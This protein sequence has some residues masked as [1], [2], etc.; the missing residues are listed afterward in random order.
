[1]HWLRILHRG[2]PQRCHLDGGRKSTGQSRGLHR[3]RRMRRCLPRTGNQ[4]GVK[5]DGRRQR[6]E[7]GSQKTE[8]SRPLSVLCHQNRPHRLGR[9]RTPGF[10]PGNRGSNPLGAIGIFDLRFPIFDFRCACLFFPAGRLSRCRF[11]LR[12]IYT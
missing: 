10:Q 11:L 4:Y 3:L 5:T 9:S 2:M 7:N 8:Y 12:T 6:T 1:M